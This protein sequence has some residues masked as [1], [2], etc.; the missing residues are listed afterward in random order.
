MTLFADIVSTSLQVASTR[1][2][3]KKVEFLTAC[4]RAL[5]PD[6]IETGVGYLAGVIPGGALGVGPAMVRDAMPHSPA[7][8]PGLELLEVH[9]ELRALPEI[10]GAGSKT[11]RTRRLSQ[12]LSRSTAD[13]QHFLA[14]LIIGE[15]RHGALQGIMT[16]A[17]A[18]AAELDASQIRRAVMLSG[19]LVR[20]GHVALTEGAPGLEEFRIQVFR[21]VQP[22]LAQTASDVGEALEKLGSTVLEY[23][24]DGARVQVHKSGD[25]VRVYTRRLNE[26]TGS[27]PEVVEA[28]RALP[29][30]TTI[31][32]GEV[33]AL[34]E[35]GKPQPF[36]VT[37]RRFGRRKD[38]AAMREKLPLDVFF[39]DALFR[40]G[41]ELIDRPAGERLEFMDA[42]LPDG[43]VIP[44]STSMDADAGEAFY[45]QAT[46]RGH[47]GIMAK[48]LD[49]PY[50]AGSRGASWLKIK[51]AH[52][53]D[54]VV[55]ACEWGSGRRKGWLSNLH[56]GAFDAATQQFVMLGKTF[57][58]LTDDMLRWQTEAFLEREVSRD[59]WTVYLR[60][61]IVVEI[62][63]NELQ[64]SPQYPGGLALRFARVKRYREDKTAAE[65]DTMDAVRAIHAGQRR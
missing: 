12:L 46:G 33:L 13:E 58:G 63:F 35:D 60:P 61:E 30:D 1:S 10:T 5:K 7:D 53:L 6:E 32:D 4:L 52:T 16:D 48:S 45:Q 31:L 9:R 54:L 17:I 55:L 27:V 50:E 29:V 64:E 34:R 23:K 59:E 40:D 14:R 47:E 3:L 57:K 25:E 38:V 15:I 42:T 62:A 11:E 18:A 2:R 22:M 8:S 26:V 49:A 51:P 41:T 56:L 65:A 44:R 19:D 43:L 20:A 39:F 36:Q 37:M 21:P 28:V 24:L